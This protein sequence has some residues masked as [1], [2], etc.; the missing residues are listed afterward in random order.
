METKESEKEIKVTTVEW[1]SH[2]F[3]WLD[4]LSNHFAKS[5][6]GRPNKSATVRRAVIK[7]YKEVCVDGED[8]N[9]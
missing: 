6:G 2:E 9:V 5:E 8:N 7:L 1:E 4:K 3:M